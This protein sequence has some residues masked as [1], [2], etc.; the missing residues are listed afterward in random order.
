M[1]SERRC[2]RSVLDN[3]S[4]DALYVG[5][6]CNLGINRLE[7][8]KKDDRGYETRVR[9]DRWGVDNDKLQG[10]KIQTT[11]IYISFVS[12]LVWNIGSS[13]QNISCGKCSNH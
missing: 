2:L 13:L 1:V 11:A 12:H 3:G 6:K 9:A 10:V 5:V 4:T 8:M 7:R